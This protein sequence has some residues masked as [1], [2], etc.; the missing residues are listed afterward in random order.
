MAAHN[1]ADIRGAFYEGPSIHIFDGSKLFEDGSMP[2]VALRSSQG[3][4]K[5]CGVREIGIVP[6]YVIWQVCCIVSYIKGV[7]II[8]DQYAA[9]ALVIQKILLNI[10]DRLLL[11]PICP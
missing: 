6:G 2:S 11:M 5:G 3:F 1:I 8:S 9:C 4:P 7:I 10:C